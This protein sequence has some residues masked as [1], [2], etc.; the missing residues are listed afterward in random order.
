MISSN[1]RDGLS[2]KKRHSPRVIAR[3]FKRAYQGFAHS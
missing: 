3:R 2:R 1:S